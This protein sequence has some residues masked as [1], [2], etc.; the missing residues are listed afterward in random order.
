LIR[1]HLA[2]RLQILGLVIAKNQPLAFEPHHANTL[3]R[4]R[5]ERKPFVLPFFCKESVAERQSPEC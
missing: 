1:F 5:K 4:R 3:N 2:I